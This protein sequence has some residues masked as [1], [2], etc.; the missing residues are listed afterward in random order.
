MTEPIDT[1]SRMEEF[2]R[3]RSDDPDSV[4]LVDYQLITGGYSRQMSRVWIEDG[5]EKR[6]YIVRQD[7]PPGQAII[8]T[9]RATEWDVLSTLHKSGRIPMPAPL[10][11][12]PTGEELGSPGIVIEMVQ[13]EALVSVG[14]KCD[15]SE[16]PK[17]APRMA[18]VGGALAAFPLEEAPASLEV[19]A[20]W[21]DY[22]DARI[23]Y[24]VDAEKKHI[25][26]DPFMRLIGAYLRSNRPPPVP[27]GLVHGDFQVANILIADDPKNDVIVDWELAHIGDPREDLGWCM[28]ASVTQP[29][30][31]VA[32]DEEAFYQRY[33]EISGLNEEQVN[34]NTTDYFLLLASST[35][36]VNVIE[37]LALLDEGKTTGIQLA[38]MSPAVAGMHDVFYRAL[39]RHAA[40]T[41][42]EVISRR[43]R[44]ADRCRCAEL[45][46]K[47]A[48]ADH[49][50][51]RSRCSSRWRWRCCRR[52]RAA[53][54]VS[55]RGCRRSG[56]PSSRPPA[57]CSTPC[58]TPSRCRR[59]CRRTRTG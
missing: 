35:V 29:P 23:Q 39:K 28:M 41:E 40:A 24:W 31:I 21:D 33:R 37:Q 30:D 44:A 47:V 42:V 51:R 45:S 32:S 58:P 15:P 13:S 1:R 43:P 50:R 53:A 6:G 3:R 12:D 19:P 25:D 34:P 10:W 22:I 18:E 48:P 55:W 54:A 4:K 26:R 27:L 2:F 7:P 5:G 57:S 46:S 9:D 8:E 14:R 11:F 17:F 59:R 49:R 52:R 20:S 36:F 56:T 16:L 38:Y